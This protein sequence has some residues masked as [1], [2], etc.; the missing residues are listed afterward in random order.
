MRRWRSFGRAAIRAC[1]SSKADGLGNLCILG[2][3]YICLVDA[4]HQPA[5]S[6]SMRLRNCVCHVWAFALGNTLTQFGE[7]CDWT[8]LKKKN[9]IF[10]NGKCFYTQLER[11]WH[12]LK[13][14]KNK[15]KL[16]CFKLLGWRPKH[17][18]LSWWNFGYFRIPRSCVSNCMPEQKEIFILCRW[19][20][21]S[22]FL[23]SLPGVRQSLPELRK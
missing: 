20:S 15:L 10:G 19:L 7:W 3:R 9:T 5:F 13:C 21:A 1:S 2:T 23:S 16:E 12:N 8:S 6:W 17:T 4:F 18:Y 14:L 11:H 22:R